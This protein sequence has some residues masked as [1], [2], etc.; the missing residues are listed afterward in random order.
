MEPLRVI[1]LP[2]VP[3][4]SS[5][6]VTSSQI[7]RRPALVL[8]T[9]PLLNKLELGPLLKVHI[10]KL[11]L[12]QD[13]VECRL[14]LI[15]RSHFD[16]LFILLYLAKCN[17]INVPSFPKLLPALISVCLLCLRWLVASLLFTLLIEPMYAIELHHEILGEGPASGLPDHCKAEEHAL[18][19]KHE[20]SEEDPL[21]VL[22][23]FH[24]YV[25]TVLHLNQI[26]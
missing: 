4:V 20:G 11:L 25:L 3:S 6:R 9:I 17:F 19:G 1:Q 2:R 24:S 10:T 18:K 7:L 8:I 5:I 13:L 15:L 14:L 16:L 26:I 21:V 23:Q 22:W 12:L